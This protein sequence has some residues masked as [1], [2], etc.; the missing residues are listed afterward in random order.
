MIQLVALDLDGTLIGD[1]FTI[2]DNVCQAVAE[3][4]AH[5]VTVTLATG[6]MFESTVPFAR[7][8]NITAPLICYQGGLIQAP[9]A[10][11]PL[12]QATMDPALVREALA[13]QMERGWHIVIYADDALFAAERRYPEDF[14]RELLG[15]NFHWVDDW[16]D[17]LEQRQPVKFLFVA[18]PSEADVIEAAMRER[19]EGQMEIVRSHA[20]F[21]EGN[22]LGVSKGEALRRL[23]DHLDVPQSQVMAVGDQGNDVTMIEWAGVGVAMENGSAAVKAVADWVA[24]PLKE[25]GAATAIRQF[26]LD[27]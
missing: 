5:G 6:R 24:P 13:W 8:L 14:Y 15:Q 25:D 10:E 16:A 27:S 17:V 9:A 18:E 20:M 26:V 19:F 4:Q 11:G 1:Q 22:P 3:A 21:V 23:A 7:R 12:Y 2:S